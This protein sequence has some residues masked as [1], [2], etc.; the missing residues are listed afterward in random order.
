MKN[1]IF[2]KGIKGGIRKLDG[3][4]VERRVAIKNIRSTQ[5]SVDEKQ[6][7]RLARFTRNMP[8]TPTV[9]HAGGGKYLIY[10]GNHRVAA[11]LKQGKR[12]ITV[13]VQ[14]LSARDELNRIIQLS[15]TPNS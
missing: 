4:T 12:V 5:E 7:S 10:D 14:K 3:P 6:V 2:Q 1:P 8:G 9:S 13:K 15:A 11:A